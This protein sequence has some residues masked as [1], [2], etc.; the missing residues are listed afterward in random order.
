MEQWFDETLVAIISQARAYKVL[1][2]PARSCHTHASPRY[3][4]TPEQAE[5]YIEKEYASSVLTVAPE[6][7]KEEQA[8]RF[9]IL[10]KADAQEEIKL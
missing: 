6:D 1:E 4:R 10:M 5:R 3:F 9:A 8:R 7:I 2:L